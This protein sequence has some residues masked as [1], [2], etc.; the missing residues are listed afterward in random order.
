MSS[1]SRDSTSN[2]LHDT[3]EPW[4]RMTMGHMHSLIKWMTWR[5]MKPRFSNLVAKHS[6]GHPSG[7]SIRKYETFEQWSPVC[8][9]GRVTWKKDA[10]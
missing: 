5:K 8:L 6:I 3:I 2:Q 7:A 10:T 4:E 1:M 9:H